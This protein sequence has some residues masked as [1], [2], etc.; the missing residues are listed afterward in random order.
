MQG[1]KLFETLLTRAA[2]LVVVTCICIAGA[3]APAHAQVDGLSGGSFSGPDISLGGT[4]VSTGIDP[5]SLVD[6]SFGLDQVDP[7]SGVLVPDQ[8]NASLGDDGAIAQSM[9]ENN[10]MAINAAAIS[11]KA[12]QEAEAKRQ[13]ALKAQTAA[14]QT[15]VGP[16]G[17]PSQAPANTMREGSDKIGV[18]ALCANSVAQARSGAAAGAVKQSLKQLGIPYSLSPLRNT[19]HMDCSSF[20]SRAYRDT[21]TPIPL[22]SG[23]NPTTDTFRAAKWMTKI[24]LGEAKPGDL[25][26]PHAGHVAMKLSDGFMVHTNKT[27][28]VAHVK[29]LYTSAYWVGYVEPSKL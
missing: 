10:L 8:V 21:G 11:Q 28:D 20:V 4:G 29:R 9:L 18:A 7:L 3:A 5:A 27:G 14:N 12:A 22:F 13:A 16:D 23:N 2:A 24:S 25:V 6:S 19:T 17:C 15:G 1:V 26:E